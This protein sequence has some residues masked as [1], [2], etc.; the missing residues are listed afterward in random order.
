MTPADDIAASAG[1]VRV[2]LVGP[3]RVYVDGRRVADPPAGRA[4]SLLA[5]L[6]VDAGHLVPI[7]RIIDDLWPDGPPAKAKE[8]VASLVSRLRRLVGRERIE[9]SR[10]GYRLVLADDV[11]IDLRDAEA[12]VLDAER[13]L[14]S[15][16]FA[17]ACTAARDVLAILDAG[18]LLEDDPYAQWAEAP[19]RRAEA[20]KRRARRTLWTAAL[21]MDDPRSAMEAASAAV[22]SDPFDEEAHRALMRADHRRGDRGAALA[23]LQAARA[24]PAG[25]DGRRS[26]PRDRRPVRG[27]R[28]RQARAGKLRR[29]RRRQRAAPVT[30]RRAGERTGGVAPEVERRGRRRQRP[31]VPLRAAGIGQ[32]PAGLGGRRHGRGRRWH[33]PQ[34]PVQRGGALLVPPADP[35]GAARV[36]R[37]RPRRRGPGTGRELGGHHRRA[38]AQRP[39]PP[40]ETPATSGPGRSW[41]TAARS[42]R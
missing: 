12:G 10:S 26:G 30:A 33:R 23:R 15:G 38:A 8:N 42:K 39:R 28:G 18:E 41:S 29:A 31:R 34:G 6:A 3:L 32:V 5:L 19:R 27:D 17:P 35:R 16:A 24:Q 22:E 37:E 36:P 11:R 25:G 13:Q 14:F 9:G 1:S 2:R 4:A 21:E 7:D 20:L 40:R